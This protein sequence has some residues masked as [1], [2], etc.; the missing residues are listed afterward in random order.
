MQVLV[1]QNFG[2]KLLPERIDV[3]DFELLLEMLPSDHD[4]VRRLYELDASGI[5]CYVLKRICSGH[6]DES[7]EEASQL[8]LEKMEEND[9][10]Q[11]CEKEYIFNGMG[12]L[13]CSTILE[14]C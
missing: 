5:P 10:K 14:K 1:G 9:F 3:K 13:P 11:K 8:L 2:E 12:E 6:S 4:A 7:I